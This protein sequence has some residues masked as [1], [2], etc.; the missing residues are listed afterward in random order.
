[1]KKRISVTATLTLSMVFGTFILPHSTSAKAAPMSAPLFQ[2]NCVVTG[3]NNTPLRVRA[4]PGGRVIGSLK[5]GAN[6]VAYG[7]EQDRYGSDWTKIR[8]RK[9][10][11]FV[12][13]TFVSCG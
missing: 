5:I 1:M 9:G 8:Y 12:S 4:T 2:D 6:I 7:I 13:T 10:Y 3:T 11:G